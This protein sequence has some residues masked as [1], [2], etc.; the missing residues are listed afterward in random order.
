MGYSQVSYTDLLGFA[1]SLLHDF[2]SN[3]IGMGRLLLTKG[4]SKS[5][6]AQYV[7]QFVSSLGIYPEANMTKA[8]M[9]HRFKNGIT[10]TS[11]RYA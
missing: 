10:N 7:Y 11:P 1:L 4:Y 2:L 6:L 5:K 3:A 9:C 8:E